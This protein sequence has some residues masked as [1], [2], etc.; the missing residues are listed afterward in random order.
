M[1]ERYP[2]SKLLQ[3]L[4]VQELAGRVPGSQD[5]NGWSS[6][7]S[8]KFTHACTSLTTK[9]SRGVRDGSFCRAFSERVSQ[10]PKLD[11]AILNA[12]IA[13]EQF[14]IAEGYERPSIL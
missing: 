4:L 3:V 11:V 13:T 2:L 1:H 8:V 10:L 14:G 9:V 6:F 5:F 7:H 12:A